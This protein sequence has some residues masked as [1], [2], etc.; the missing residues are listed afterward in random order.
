MSKRQHPGLPAET[1][2]APGTQGGSPAD[3]LQTTPQEAPPVRLL[4]FWRVPFFYGWVIVVAVFVAEFV[5]SG[6]GTFVTP[7][8]FKA[9]TDDMGWTLTMLT[10]ALTA[11]TLANALVAPVLGKALDRLGARPVM[12]FGAIAAGLGLL[13]LTRIHAIW[14]FW[15]LYGLV[16][17]LGLAEM[18][19]FTGPVLITKWFTRLRGRAMA[20]SSMGTTIGGVVMAPIVGILIASYGWRSAWMVLGIFVLTVTIPL[21]LA[22]VR[23]QPEDMGLRPD[24]DKS[25]TQRAAGSRPAKS[26]RYAGTDISWTVKEAM[27][28][29]T[30]W[31]LIVGLNLVNLAAN[32]TVFS[33]VPFLTQQE[34]MA[35]TAAGYVVSMRLGASTM[36]RLV[37]GWAVDHFPMNWCLAAGFFARALTSL[38]LL[39]PF[40]VNVFSVIALSVLGGGFQVLQP[41]AFANYFGRDHAGAIQGAT[42]PFLIVSSLVGPLFIAFVFDVTGSFDLGFLVAGVMGLASACIGVFATAPLKKEA[43]AA[44][45][46]LS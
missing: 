19:G 34:G 28:T 26:R 23:N 43:P 18:G 32:V 27:R 37:W 12:L 24:G 42:R 45:A 29:R 44:A 17:A 21:V 15:L 14:Q 9:M 25:G 46:P 16:G 13:L 40:P 39:L 41:M 22:T 30:L 5:A 20:I 38:C 8:F 4:G 10:G 7:L 3:P 1:P 35:V 36:S 2:T 11:Q 6:V 33:L 31:I